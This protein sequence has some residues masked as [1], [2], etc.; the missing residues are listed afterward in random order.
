LKVLGDTW[1]ERSKRKSAL[2]QEQE[3][4]K[5][6]LALSETQIAVIRA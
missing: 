2:L 6:E 3:R 4:C 1:V 5:T